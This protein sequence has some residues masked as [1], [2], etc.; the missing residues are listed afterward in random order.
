MLIGEI[1]QSMKQFII[2]I[3]WGND[4]VRGAS[5]GESAE[6]AMRIMRERC[7]TAT[8]IEHI[9]PTIVVPIVAEE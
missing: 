9:D 8:S 7:P 2:Q 1:Q 3:N 4:W 5:S 6:D